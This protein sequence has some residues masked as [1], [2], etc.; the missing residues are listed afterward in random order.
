MIIQF[1]PF[2]LI[3]GAVYGVLRLVYLRCSKKG[4]KGAGA[5]LL[6]LCF[7]C[8]IFAL[9]ALVWVP[10]GFWEGVWYFI[11]KGEMPYSDFKLFC[12]SYSGRNLVLQCL[13][14]NFE[15]VII[16]KN[17]IIANI[18]MFVPLGFFLPLVFKKIKPIHSV[19]ICL[20]ATCVIEAVQPV[21][22]R[23]GDLDDI[24]AN[25]LGGVIGAVIAALFMGARARVVNSE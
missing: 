24:A 11:E 6:L 14:G 7:V 9:I 4:G 10:E 15:G 19:F 25:F 17:S 3:V 1:F 2:M 23:T 13:K 18:I 20:A 5:E 12:G 22:G 8:Y 21:V 16:E